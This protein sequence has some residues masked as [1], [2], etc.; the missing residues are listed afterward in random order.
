MWTATAVKQRRKP[1]TDRAPRMISAT[2]RVCSMANGMWQVQRRDDK[3]KGGDARVD[4]WKGLFRPTTL[5]AAMRQT[6]LV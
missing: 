5:A 6:K 2:V 1:A 3:D 4:P